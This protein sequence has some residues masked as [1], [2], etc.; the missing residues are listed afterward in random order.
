MVFWTSE[1]HDNREYISN[2]S[3]SNLIK[4]DFWNWD[5]SHLIFHHFGRRPD[6]VPFQCQSHV[7]SFYKILIWERILYIGSSLGFIYTYYLEIYRLWNMVHI[8][9]NI[10]IFNFRSFFENGSWNV[11]EPFSHFAWNYIWFVSQTISVAVFM[12][13]TIF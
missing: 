10:H 6:G 8:I 4:Y 12:L 3:V 7:D 11:W 9:W 13:L 1:F 2:T 5:S